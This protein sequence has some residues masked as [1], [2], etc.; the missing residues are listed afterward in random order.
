MKLLRSLSTLIF[1]LVLL[2]SWTSLAMASS[3]TVTKVADTNDGVCNS[4]CSLREAIAAASAGDTVT[5]D[6]TLAGQTIYLTSSLLIDKNLTVDGSNLAPHIQVSGDTNND[7]TGDVAVLQVAAGSTVEL[8]GLDVIKGY[9]SSSYP[10]I[11]GGIT[12]HGTLTISNS[13][14]SE[15]FNAGDGGGIF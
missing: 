3:L 5:F 11:S 10:M 13:T 14:I 12:N 7:G 6:P 8:D 9:F 2:G 15:N 4:D 1:V